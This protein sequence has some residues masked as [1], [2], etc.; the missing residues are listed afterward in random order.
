MTPSHQHRQAEADGR[1]AARLAAESVDSWLLTEANASL[2]LGMQVHDELVVRVP[3]TASTGYRWRI[4]DSD[5]GALTLVSDR[6]VEP[7]VGVLGATRLRSLR[8]LATGPGAAKVH[9][10][11]SRAFAQ[12]ME[13]ETVEVDLDVAAPV[14]GDKPRRL[15]V[16]WR[17]ELAVGC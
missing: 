13:V 12:E 3:E 17:R 16:C 14:T 1:E 15:Y 10:G 2:K 5:L 11:L 4:R 9:L 7:E 6:S 8:F